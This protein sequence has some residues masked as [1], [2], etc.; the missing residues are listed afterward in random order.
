M[1]E[2]EALADSIYILDRGRV[3]VSGTISEL[4]SGGQ[5]LESVYLANTHAQVST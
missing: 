3:A 5:N 1:D 2:A 4:T